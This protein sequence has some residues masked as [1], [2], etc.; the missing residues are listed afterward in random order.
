M[1]FNWHPGSRIWSQR[2]V[3]SHATNPAQSRAILC[4]MAWLRSSAQARS[5]RSRASRSIR[6]RD[7]VLS[8]SMP[9]FSIAT[10]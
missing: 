5:R 7:H 2:R 9:S 8:W 1:R 6:R 10:C 3:S 4:S